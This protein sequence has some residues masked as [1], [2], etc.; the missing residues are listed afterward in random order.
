MQVKFSRQIDSRSR[1]NQRSASVAS[2]GDIQSASKYPSLAKM[3]S[4]AA[5][6]NV[7]CSTD[8]LPQINSFRESPAPVHLRTIQSTHRNMRILHN[9]E[10]LYESPD[11]HRDYFA[12]YEPIK[13]RNVKSMLTTQ[14]QAMW[15]PGYAEK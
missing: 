4:A 1:S 5:A 15:T 8:V 6:Y 2:R 3:E 10:K 13:H 14:K 7:R 12:A 9:G 11:A